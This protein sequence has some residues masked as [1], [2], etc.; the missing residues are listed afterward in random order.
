[1]KILLIVV[2]IV[3]LANCTPRNNLNDAKARYLCRDNSGLYA[4]YLFS[5][6]PVQCNDGTQFSIK[7]LQEVTIKDPQYLPRG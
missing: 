4:F 7:Q 5:E 3:T 1:M 6:Y 2:L